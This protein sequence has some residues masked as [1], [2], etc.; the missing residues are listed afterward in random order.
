MWLLEGVEYDNHFR[1]VCLLI[2][3]LG[4]LRWMTLIFS[5]QSV[6]MLRMPPPCNEVDKIN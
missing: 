1:S 6:I 5:G 4:E 2:A 3:F